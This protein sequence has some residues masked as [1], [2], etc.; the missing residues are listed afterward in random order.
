MI[1][2]IQLIINYSLEHI[3]N[4]SNDNGIQLNLNA[5]INAGRDNGNVDCRLK[6][7]D[8]IPFNN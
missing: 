5:A 4:Q 2:N 3:Q 1:K 6:R 8:Y 7:V